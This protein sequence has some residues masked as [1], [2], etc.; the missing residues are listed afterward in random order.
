MNILFLNYCYFKECATTHTHTCMYVYTYI[1]M[2]ILIYN[3]DNVIY[4]YIPK[5]GILV[6]IQP[7]CAIIS[8]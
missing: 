3:I 2:Y 7:T 4:I 6:V 5:A 8:V 1:H